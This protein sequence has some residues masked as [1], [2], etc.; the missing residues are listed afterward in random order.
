LDPGKRGLFQTFV[1]KFQRILFIENLVKHLPSVPSFLDL[2]RTPTVPFFLNSL[3]S[4]SI[5]ND[6]QRSH[7][8]W[9]LSVPLPSTTTSIGPNLYCWFYFYPLWLPLVPPPLSVRL[10]FIMTSIFLILSYPPSVLFQFV[11]T[12]IG[13]KFSWQQ[14]LTY[15][16]FKLSQI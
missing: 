9:T 6:L 13:P 1:N 7:F 3:S 14:R 11:I 16:G 15:D 12:S 10:L 2:L 4:T 5:H 8:S